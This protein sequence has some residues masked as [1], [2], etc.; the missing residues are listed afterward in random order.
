MG[1]NGKNSYLSARILQCLGIVLLVASAVF[2]AITGQQSEL[3][4]GA[5]MSLITL[6]SYQ[7]LR[8]SVK[9]EQERIKGSNDEGPTP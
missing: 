8:V 9:N 3:F 6:G 4:V 1:T 5:A 7:G 2:W